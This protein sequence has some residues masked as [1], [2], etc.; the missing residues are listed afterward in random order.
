[1]KPIW[2]LFFSLAYVPLS[3]GQKGFSFSVRGYPQRQLDC[4]AGADEVLRRFT[5]ATDVKVLG[6]DC[7][8]AFFSRGL[9]ITIRY[10]SEDPL[11]I[12]SNGPWPLTR[13]YESCLAKLDE[14]EA[15]FTKTT[16]LKPYLRYCAY[17]S[18]KSSWEK[19]FIYLFTPVIYA[20]GKPTA[21]IKSFSL[22]MNQGGYFGGGSVEREIVEK[23]RALNIPMVEARIDA[24]RGTKTFSSDLWL[25]FAVSPE[26]AKRD[27]KNDFLLNDR[28][29]LLEI[30]GESDIDPMI[31]DSIEKCEAQ[32]KDVQALFPAE[33]FVWFCMWDHQLFRSQLYHLRI[34]PGFHRYDK[35]VPGDDNEPLLNRFESHEECL[36][37]REAVVAHYKSKLGDKVIGALCSWKDRLKPNLPVRMLL[38]TKEDQ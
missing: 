32:R 25:R 4:K 37:E 30:L 2:Y 33:S 1:M 10:V 6:T 11:P 24:P 14:E 8:P 17:H 20:M 22:P 23:S 28:L 5:Q 29:E 38:Y 34:K 21:L 13:S 7:K 27:V 26:K 12:V 16:G 36:K 31:A 19:S 15:L 18:D 9:D 35:I 3:F